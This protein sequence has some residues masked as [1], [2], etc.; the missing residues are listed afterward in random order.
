MSEQSISGAVVMNSYHSLLILYYFSRSETPTPSPASMHLLPVGRP[1]VKDLLLPQPSPE[2]LPLPQ[3]SPAIDATAPMTAGLHDLHQ[4][5]PDREI[6]GA[7][8]MNRYHS[9]LNI[10]LFFR[11][12]TSTP[13]LASMHLYPMGKPGVEGLQ[14]LPLTYATVH[15]LGA[16]EGVPELLPLTYPSVHPLRPFR[17]S[18]T[19]MT[20]LVLTSYQLPTAVCPRTL[21]MPLMFYFMNQIFLSIS[22]E[23]QSNIPVNQE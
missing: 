21:F 1:G 15:P 20:L 18:T 5:T 19:D 22:E 13:S 14:L 16:I 7:V 3:P 2:D 11:S 4:S 17:G 23:A 8:R 10:P 6:S 12:E 9:L